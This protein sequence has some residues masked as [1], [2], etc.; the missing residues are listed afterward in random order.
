MNI[1]IFCVGKVKETYIQDAIKEY[2]KRISKYAE[3]SICEVADEMIP[4]NPSEKDLKNIKKLEADKILK[5]I[6]TSDFVI[7]LDLRGKELSS[8]E[9]AEKLQSITV[10]GFSTICFT[11]SIYSSNAA[12]IILNEMP[13][14]LYKKEF[15]WSRTSCISRIY[16]ISAIASPFSS[17]IGETEV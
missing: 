8:E 13:S 15:R 10:N 4:A 1:K 14:I 7:A 3:I 11:R 17:R 12:P 6:K 9:F 2:T 16:C 5:Q